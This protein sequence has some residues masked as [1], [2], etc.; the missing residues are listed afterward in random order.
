MELFNEILRQSPD[1]KIRSEESKDF[2]YAVSRWGEFIN[3]MINI[4][5]VPI[6]KTYDDFE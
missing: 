6:P 5:K 3:D 1:G 2:V 4:H